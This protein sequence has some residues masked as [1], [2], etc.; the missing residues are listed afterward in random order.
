MSEHERLVAQADILEA[1]AAWSLQ[2]DVPTGIPGAVTV[3]DLRLRAVSLRVQAD[4]L[5]PE[6]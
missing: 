3:E 2:P 6:A 1:M 5:F 4:V